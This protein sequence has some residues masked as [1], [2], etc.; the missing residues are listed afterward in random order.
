MPTIAR[1]KQ[2]ARKRKG[3]VW[4]VFSA[5]LLALIPFVAP[6]TPLAIVLALTA[7]FVAGIPAARYGYLDRPSKTAL[8]LI[9][10]VQGLAIAFVGFIA[11]PRITVSPGR[12]SFRGYPNETFDF[13]VRNGRSDDVYDLQ[14]PF[15]IGYNKHLQ[16]KLSAKVVP[17]NDPQEAISDDYNYC[18]GKKG[19]GVVSWSGPQN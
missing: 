17:N 7:V 3:H 11:W 19:D 16:D 4:Q 14:I 9:L 5:V 12:V 1:R 8:A 15:L 18:F 10:I 13:S 6:K 2:E